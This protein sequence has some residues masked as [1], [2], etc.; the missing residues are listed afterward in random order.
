MAT[1]GN[2]QE[3]ITYAPVQR[4]GDYHIK[5]L[6]ATDG[7]PT[8]LVCVKRVDLVP[9]EVLGCEPANPGEVV[10]V[11][12]S[13]PVT[14]HDDAELRAFAYDVTDPVTANESEPSPNAGILIFT[15]PGRP[16]FR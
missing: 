12:V 14:P 10:V 15:P 9:H 1:D 16:E 11:Q 6:P 8:A 7:V 2:A 4:R 3:D 5:V 13:V